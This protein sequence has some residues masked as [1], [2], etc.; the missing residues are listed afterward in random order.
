MVH[1]LPPPTLGGTRLTQLGHVRAGLAHQMAMVA[2]D[3]DGEAVGKAT[4]RVQS[5]G[6]SH[7]QGFDL[8]H[9]WEWQKFLVLRGPLARRSH[10]FKPGDV[11]RR[12]G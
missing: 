11:N 6:G 5:G 1:S 4:H 7:V 12:D 2:K 9:S 3:L 10:N 8:D